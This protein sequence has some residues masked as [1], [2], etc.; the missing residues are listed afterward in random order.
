MTLGCFEE[1]I[2]CCRPGC[3]RLLVETDWLHG[4][5]AI[6]IGGVGVVRR[7]LGV[8]LAITRETIVGIS[9]WLLVAVISRLLRCAGLIG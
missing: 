4:A 9:R 5:S 2:Q 6:G 1:L 8:R 7:Y 3:F